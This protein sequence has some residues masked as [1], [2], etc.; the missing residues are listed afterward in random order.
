[1]GL[2]WDGSD[3][4]GCRLWWFRRRGFGTTFRRKKF[5]FREI[6][7]IPLTHFCLLKV[8]QYDLL[9]VFVFLKRLSQFLKI[10]FLYSAIPSC[11]M[12][13]YFVIIS[14]NDCWILIFHPSSWHRS[15]PFAGAWWYLNF[16]MR[17]SKRFI[18]VIRY[19]RLYSVQV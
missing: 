17:I 15:T 2:S 18:I 1:M 10:P 19:L 11:L 14:S 4:A 9:F 12:K 7:G 16:F 13:Q 5:G 6:T 8:S 3:C